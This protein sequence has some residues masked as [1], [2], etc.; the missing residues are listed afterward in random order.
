MRRSCGNCDLVLQKE[1]AKL[2][3]HA[4]LPADPATPHTVQSLEIELSLVLD[5]NEPHR[6]P[7]HGFGNRFRI[8]VVVLVRL[9]E[10]PDL[11]CRHELYVMPLPGESASEEM[12]AGAGFDPRK[13]L[14]P[15]NRGC[16]S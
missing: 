14:D 1:P 11:L 16:R 15:R 12:G 6:R 10:W 7:L 3:D 13:T 4:S 2:I 8:H 5:G 9:D